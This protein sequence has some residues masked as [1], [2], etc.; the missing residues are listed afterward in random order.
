MTAYLEV[1]GLFK[2][3]RDTREN[4]NQS[5]LCLS[6]G[7]FFLYSMITCVLLSVSLGRFRSQRSGWSN[8][9]TASARF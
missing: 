8:Y 6:K 4:A 1:D 9:V 3:F 7:S 5:E 2:Q